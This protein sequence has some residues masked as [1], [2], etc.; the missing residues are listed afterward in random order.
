[1]LL[2]FQVANH[3]S[4]RDEQTLHMQPVY[5]KSHPAAGGASAPVGEERPI[6]SSSN[7]SKNRPPVVTT[8][9]ITESA[10]LACTWSPKVHAGVS[11]LTILS[12]L[13]SLAGR[14][15]TP[16]WR[17]ERKLVTRGRW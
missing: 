6:R 8:F 12:P 17:S 4:I 2:S 1:V 11:L 3:K 7:V 14:I 10:T 13:S 5:D 15:E 16:G 9:K